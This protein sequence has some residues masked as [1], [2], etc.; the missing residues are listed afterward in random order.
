[1]QIRSNQRIARRLRFLLE[2][3]SQQE[4]NPTPISR[5]FKGLALL[6]L[7]FIGMNFIKYV[8]AKRKRS[9]V[10]NGGLGAIPK[11][12]PGVS[13]FISAALLRLVSVLRLLLS[14]LRQV[15]R[16]FFAHGLRMGRC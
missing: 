2:L 16:R 11:V 8:A 12:P 3:N 10:A 4:I 1:M 7:A 13:G 9:I 5:R 6:G 14:L 15:L